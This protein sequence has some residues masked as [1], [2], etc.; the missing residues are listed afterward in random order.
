[1]SVRQF[2]EELRK[3]LPHPVYLL[4]S[5]EE[6]LLY[7]ALSLIRR[8]LG[9][10]DLFNFEVFD[11]DSPDS[12]VTM[13]QVLDA[14]NTLPMMA[15]RRTVVLRNVQ[16]VPKKEIRELGAYMESPSG[17]TL[18]VILFSGKLSKG[19]ELS[20]HRGVR[21]IPLFVGEAELPRWI[22]A[23]GSRLGKSFSDA[24][25][26][27][28]IESVG[29]DL[30]MLNSEVEK[31]ASFAGDA[32]DVD[33]VKAVVYAGI[34]HSGF[35][36][37]RALMRGDRKE[38]F[39]IHSTLSRSV[40]PHQLIGA[41]N[42]QFRKLWEGIETGNTAEERKFSIIFRLLH[43]ADVALKT[44]HEHVIEDVLVKLLKIRP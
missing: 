22:K 40:E 43:E 32:V 9:G 41:L 26:Q 42:W 21:T 44:S 2:Q 17:T 10:S 34:E 3:A 23:K 11:A 1:M 19:F 24:A 37:V 7:E 36:L 8:E 13:E 16:S 25:A 31:F 33:E 35:D 18:L 5:T 12:P 15:P 38:V 39:R 4:H 6:F 14:L 20:G 30:G 28:L 27:L 29:T